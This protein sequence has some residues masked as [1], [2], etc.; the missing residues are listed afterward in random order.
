MDL[1]RFREGH[2]LPR[3]HD[4]TPPNLPTGRLQAMEPQPTTTGPLPVSHGAHKLADFFLGPGRHQIERV[5]SPLERL[6]L[7]D[8]NPF[9]LAD[10]LSSLAYPSQPG[11]IAPSRAGSPNLSPSDQLRC[12]EEAA[13]TLSMLQQHAPARQHNIVPDAQY[14]THHQPGFPAHDYDDERFRGMHEQ[15][16]RAF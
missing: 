7:N 9:Y 1:E 8:H 10:P 5:L 16:E 14:T 12:D 13:L 6:E 3:L 2:A 4:E 11:S 15:N